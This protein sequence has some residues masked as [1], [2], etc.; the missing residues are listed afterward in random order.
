MSN[1]ITIVTADNTTAVVTPAEFAALMIADTIDLYGHGTMAGFKVYD[2]YGKHR[3]SVPAS[4]A[5][6]TLTRHL[7]DGDD[8]EVWFYTPEEFIPAVEPITPSIADMYADVY[9]AMFP[10]TPR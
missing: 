2:D 3:Y 7:E 5:L 10:L 8:A 1:L 9:S 6:S 4:E